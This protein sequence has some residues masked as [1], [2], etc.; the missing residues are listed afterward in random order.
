ML[1]YSQLLANAYFPGSN[2]L[3]PMPGFKNQ[4]QGNLPSSINSLYIVDSIRVCAEP[5]LLHIPVSLGSSFIFFSHSTH[6]LMP[7]LNPIPRF[8]SNLDNNYILNPQSLEDLS[9]V[10]LEPMVFLNSHI[11]KHCRSHFFLK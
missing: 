4:D 10:E 1:S 6:L 5:H 8:F 9:K 7:F 2:Q 3:K 11:S